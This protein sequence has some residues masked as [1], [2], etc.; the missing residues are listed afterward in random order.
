MIDPAAPHKLFDAIYLE[1]AGSVW[2]VCMGD[3][4][5]DFSPKSTAKLEVDAG[6]GKITLSDL[7]GSTLTQINVPDID[8]LAST[9]KRLEVEQVG[10]HA[11]AVVDF[12]KLMK[13]RSLTETDM[14]RLSSE[15]EELIPAEPLQVKP[16]HH[17]QNLSLQK[18]LPLLPQEMRQMALDYSMERLGEPM[19]SLQHLLSKVDAVKDP[20]I[21]AF[22]AG[23]TQSLPEILPLIEELASRSKVF[24]QSCPPKIVPQAL[25]KLLDWLQNHVVF[26]AA[27]ASIPVALEQALIEGNIYELPNI[28]IFNSLHQ[29]EEDWMRQNLFKIEQNP[30]FKLEQVLLRV[31]N[32]SDH[33]ELLSFLTGNQKGWNELLALELK[34]ALSSSLL[35]ANLSPLPPIRFSQLE[36]LQ[37]HNPNLLKRVAASALPEMDSREFELFIKASPNVKKGFWILDH[38]SSEKTPLLVSYFQGKLPSSLLTRPLRM[39]ITR[40]LNLSQFEPSRPPLRDL[41]STEMREP[42]RKRFYTFIKKLNAIH[43]TRG[44]LHYRP[45]SPVTQSLWKHIIQ[46]D[47][48]DLTTGLSRLWRQHFKS[49]L[50]NDLGETLTQLFNTELSE[51]IRNE[52]LSKI[53]RRRIKPFQTLAFLNAANQAVNNP[54]DQDETSRLL[55][56][57]LHGKLPK[58]MSWN[59]HDRTHP[60]IRGFIT[61]LEPEAS[62][63]QFYQTCN[64]AL[65][66]WPQSFSEKIQLMEFSRQVSSLLSKG[67]DLPEIESWLRNV[68]R[69]L[70]RSQQTTWQTGLQSNLLLMDDSLT[71]TNTTGPLKNFLNTPDE[72]LQQKLGQL[73]EQGFSQN[74]IKDLYELFSRMKQ[75]TRKGQVEF[76]QSMIEMIRDGD[77]PKNLPEKLIQ[78]TDRL[79]DWNRFQNLNQGPLYFSIPLKMGEQT[80]SLEILYKSLSNREER[81]R[82]LVVLHLDFKSMGHFRADI[83]KEGQ[84]LSAT[85][86]TGSEAMQA[87]LHL[88]IHH[89]IEKLAQAGMANAKIAVKRHVERAATD[90]ATLS[91]RYHEGEFDLEA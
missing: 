52:L 53:L 25:Q 61:G 83:L 45:M 11:N 24:I 50:P 87:R 31:L 26:Q 1:Q 75:R 13:T 64:R 10:I 41:L 60:L 74:A 70:A 37:A 62:A 16:N 76:I 21:T 15:L 84:S 39:E 7:N 59:L 35:K 66:E 12:L 48:S 68:L 23:K 51:D 18:V 33:A 86:W 43:Q 63:S 47:A 22:L 72:K 32:E 9:M 71:D 78:F 56:Q 54:A 8:S 44:P 77:L 29:I 40:L 73:Q 27:G 49:H 67:V 34:N 17:V 85:I 28:S 58:V 55:E 80:S 79:N 5:L 4:T 69:F 19:T 82:F 90:L 81:K 36:R 57:A 89:L 2:K 42:F 30:L 3:R 91:A 38:L 88:R 20:E 65:P 46:S 14:H 6:G